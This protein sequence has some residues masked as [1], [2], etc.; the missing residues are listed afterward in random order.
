M[1]EAAEDT[2]DWKERVRTLAKAAG[3]RPPSTSITLA[4]AAALRP[5]TARATIMCSPTAKDA[6]RLP[7]FPSFMA[8][9]N[10]SVSAA[11]NQCKQSFLRDL[12][13][14]VDPDGL[15]FGPEAGAKP[16]QADAW[17]RGFF[18]RPQAEQ[19][20]V[21]QVLLSMVKS[22]G[23]LIKVQAERLKIKEAM[24]R[25]TKAQLEKRAKELEAKVQSQARQLRSRRRKRGGESIRPLTEKQT[26][27]LYIFAV[28]N[29]NYAEAARR[30]GI[31][32]K[33]FEERCKAAYVKL[34]HKGM[35]RYEMEI[36]K[37]LVARLPRDRRGQEVVAADDDGPA[38]LEG[39]KPRKATRNRRG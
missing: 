21:R 6:T 2:H 38:A 8:V 27:A 20:R 31:D 35:K 11:V 34:G 29:G 17:W 13:E 7:P 33:S 10:T 16:D 28:C 26:E 37:A 3:L 22:K 5:P 39:R 18:A 14:A 15:N 36:S 25:I 23:K 30:I 19:D 24:D 4:K 12:C 32:R 9:L 1:P